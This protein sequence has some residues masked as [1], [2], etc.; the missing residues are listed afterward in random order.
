V[1]AVVVTGAPGAGKTS[2][3]EALSDALLVDDIRHFGYERLLVAATVETDADLRAV[4]AAAG[5]EDHAVVRLEAAS[6]TLRRRLIAREP[7]DW[8]GLDELVE[9]TGRLAAAMARLVDVRLVLSTE[10]ECAQVIAERIRDAFPGALRPGGDQ[11]P[12]APLRR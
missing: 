5:A 1:F 7:A 12:Q 3:L 10:G 11:G 8:S 4:V 2:V 9:S 6:A